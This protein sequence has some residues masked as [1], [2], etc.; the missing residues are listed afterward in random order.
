MKLR[1]SKLINLL[2]KKE[3]DA[4]IEKDGKLHPIE[5]K[6]TANPEKSMI[7]NFSVIPN[8]KLG[9]GA[10]ICLSK[11]DFPI[12]EKVNTIPISYV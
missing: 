10:I 1:Y 9:E 3:I 7:K 2:E 6:K 12:S 4:I 8:E 11:T 5:I